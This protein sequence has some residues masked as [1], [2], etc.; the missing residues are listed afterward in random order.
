MMIDSEM[1]ARK[2]L[3]NQIDTSVNEL[4]QHWFTSIM[5]NVQRWLEDHAVLSTADK[6]RGAWSFGSLCLLY[7]NKRW[8]LVIASDPEPVYS[9]FVEPLDRRVAD[10]LNLLVLFYPNTTRANAMVLAPLRGRIVD[11]YQQ[12]FETCKYTLGAE[13]LASWRTPVDIERLFFLPGT[14]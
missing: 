13:T 10:L 6:V 1:D 8:Y 7:M 11:V 4:V 9:S 2:D 14:N 12:F 3:D 5:S